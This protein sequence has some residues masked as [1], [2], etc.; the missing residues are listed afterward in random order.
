MWSPS[1]SQIETCNSIQSGLQAGI[2]LEIAHGDPGIA[3]FYLGVTDGR[4]IRPVDTD[5]KGAGRRNMGTVQTAKPFSGSNN[6][7]RRR[8]FTDTATLSFCGSV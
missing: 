4:C 7:I 8:L 3:A 1:L 2:P 5:R 6:A